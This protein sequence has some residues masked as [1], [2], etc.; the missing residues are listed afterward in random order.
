LGAESRA[1]FDYQDKKLQIDVFGPE[2]EF[3]WRADLVES[4]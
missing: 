2:I 4:R 3:Y 1:I